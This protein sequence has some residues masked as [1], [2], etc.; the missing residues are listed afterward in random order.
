MCARAINE[1]EP[2]AE[3]GAKNE[4]EWVKA[5]A[6]VAPRWNQWTDGVKGTQ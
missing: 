5:V 3:V 4:L 1:V 2:M 6:G